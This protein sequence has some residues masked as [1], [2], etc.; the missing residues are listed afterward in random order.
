MTSSSSRARRQ[1]QQVQQVWLRLPLQL[2]RARLSICTCEADAAAER[3]DARHEC[4]L[5]L[6]M[7]IVTRAVALLQ[8]VLRILVH[9][10]A[11]WC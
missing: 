6:V 7:M 3:R 10:V 4:W 8:V 1:A 2:L 9:A 5:L 11:W